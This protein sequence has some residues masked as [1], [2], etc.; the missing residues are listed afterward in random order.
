[1]SETLNEI[2]E[3]YKEIIALF[4]LFESINGLANTQSLI[5]LGKSFDSGQLNIYVYLA[6]VT[7]QWVILPALPSIIIGIIINK[8]RSK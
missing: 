1:L 8:K 7:F 6:L 4:A 3:A 2:R 5:D